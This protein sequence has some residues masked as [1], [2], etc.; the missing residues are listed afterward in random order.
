[1]KKLWIWAFVIVFSGFLL[2][3][4]KPSASSTQNGWQP[5]AKIAPPALLQQ[6]RQ[7]YT[8]HLPPDWQGDIGQALML[9]LEQPGSLPLYLIDTGISPPGHPEQTPTC[10][11]LGC[12]F[13]GYIPKENGYQLV[14]NNYINDFQVQG[15]PPFI[16]PV[17]QVSY[18]VPCFHLT[19]YNA[20]TQEM[21]PTQILC[22]NGVNFVPRG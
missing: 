10:G 12:L 5:I 21:N 2:W 9:K 14:L 13:L 7:D 15:Q 19:T 22:F 4:M 3:Q 1:M 20:A 16:Q 6:F 18:N 8:P 11:M 17:E